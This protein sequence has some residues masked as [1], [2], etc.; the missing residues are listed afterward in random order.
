MPEAKITGWVHSRVMRWWVRLAWTSVGFVAPLIVAYD[1]HVS[2]QP[3]SHD[4]SDV[5]TGLLGVL[6][7][8]VAGLIGASAALLAT[9]RRPH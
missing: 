4:L 8:V 6:R 7:G 1:I 9:R 2:T 3:S 5:G